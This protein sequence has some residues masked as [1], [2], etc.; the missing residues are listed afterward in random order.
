MVVLDSLLELF[1]KNDT[2]TYILK[3]RG[4]QNKHFTKSPPAT[5]APL[6]ILINEDSASAA[7]IFAA[8]L[9]ENGRA[10]VVG[11]KSGGQ[12]S[13]GMEIPLPYEAAILVTINEIFTAKNKKLEKVGVA[14]N[15]VVEFT[16]D[17]IVQAKDRQLEKALKVLK[18]KAGKNK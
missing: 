10:E 14:P 9:Q 17:D 8:V 15:A 4:G 5:K 2:P 13:V 16:R 3:G 11:A 1:L 6:V 18:E 12:V 7:E